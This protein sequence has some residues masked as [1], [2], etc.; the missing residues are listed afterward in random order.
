MFRGKIAKIQLQ[1]LFQTTQSKK[2]NLHCFFHEHKCLFESCAWPPSQKTA[3]SIQSIE[4]QT[5]PSEWE[6]SIS[7]NED[8]KDINRIWSLK[9]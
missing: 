3:Y 1:Y 6:T 2:W 9:T 8:T 7:G 5:K 4:T